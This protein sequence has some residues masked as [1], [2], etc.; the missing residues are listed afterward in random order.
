MVLDQQRP[1]TGDTQ[2][3]VQQTRSNLRLDVV[4]H[5]A[6]QGAVKGLI[7]KRKPAPVEPYEGDA[8][9]RQGT[10]RDVDAHHGLTREKARYRFSDQA[11]ARPDV[12]YPA[13]VRGQQ[14]G[15]ILD[16]L[17]L[18]ARLAVAQPG[19]AVGEMAHDGRIFGQPVWARAA[20][21]PT[22]PGR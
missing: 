20:L 2:G 8:Q 10:R 15:Q 18:I 3:F 13:S 6:E 11:A 12:E 19:I 17:Q 14:N 22:Q 16:H 1:A 9:I 7:G 5:I 4:K 21:E